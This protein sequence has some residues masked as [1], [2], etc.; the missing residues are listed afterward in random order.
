MGKLKVG[1]MA[2]LMGA[3]EQFMPKKAN[4]SEKMSGGIYVRTEKPK[5]IRKTPKQGR[6]SIVHNSERGK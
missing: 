6:P 2:M 3:L 1:Q 4:Y 5:G